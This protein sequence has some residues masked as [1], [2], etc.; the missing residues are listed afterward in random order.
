MA[1]GREVDDVEM[2]DREGNVEM[3][4]SQESGGH[5]T[6]APVNIPSSKP[7]SITGG[8]SSASTPSPSSTP[9]ASTA[10]RLRLLVKQYFVQLTKGCSNSSCE[11]PYCAS[12][13]GP[14]RERSKEQS[15]SCVN[16]AS[17]ILGSQVLL[18]FVCRPLDEDASQCS[19]L[20]GSGPCQARG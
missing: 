11:N 2:K 15:I 18:V 8:S 12:S 5:S 3:T 1:D 10:D 16:F 14:S 6:S 4:E 20:E 19:F 7:I 17:E 9:S 13:K